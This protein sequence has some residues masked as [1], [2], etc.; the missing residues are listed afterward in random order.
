MLTPCWLVAAV[1]WW[2]TYIT[3]EKGPGRFEAGDHGL[4]GLAKAEPYKT[5]TGVAG[6]ENERPADFVVPRDR[7][8]DQPHLAEVDLELRAR[9]AIGYADRRGPRRAADAEHL[10]RITLN[11][12]LGHRHPFASQELGRLDC[13][14]V[15]VDQPGLQLV[16]VGLES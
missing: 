6:G 14:E 15:I 9:F 2:I 5:V 3:T 10:E 12:P 1:G 16:M 11:G 7:V 8:W 13:R 4:G